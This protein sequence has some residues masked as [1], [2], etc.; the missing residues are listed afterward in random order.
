MSSRMS[1]ISFVALFFALAVT[2]PATSLPLQCILNAGVVPFLPATQPTGRLGDLVMLCI[3]GSPVDAGASV[4]QVNFALFFAGGSIAPDSHPGLSINEPDAGTALLCPSLF[5]C[6]K[7]TPPSSQT[8]I[9]G[10]QVER[11]A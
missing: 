2:L 9:L 3:G 1:S 10:A 4:P 11:L 7:S 6:P 5:G 8:L